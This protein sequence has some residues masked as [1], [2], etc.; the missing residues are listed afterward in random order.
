MKILFFFS[1]SKEKISQR[2]LELISGDFEDPELALSQMSKC[3]PDGNEYKKWPKIL[4]E[5]RVLQKFVAPTHQ[6][7]VIDGDGFIIIL[8]N[9]S[10]H[11]NCAPFLIQSWKILNG[12]MRWAAPLSCA[13]D[14]EGASYSMTCPDF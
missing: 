8:S 9:G 2:D 12:E 3:L 1:R 5:R 11:A 4:K 13:F 6:I 7:H 10:G 14:V